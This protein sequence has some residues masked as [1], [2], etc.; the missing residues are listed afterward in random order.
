MDKNNNLMMAVGA[1]A[2]IFIVYV[3]CTK[4]KQTFRYTSAMPL[5]L[6]SKFDDPVVPNASTPNSPYSY[7]DMLN[8]APCSI[9]DVCSNGA[10]CVSGENHGPVCS[11]NPQKSCPSSLDWYATCVP[12]L[13]SFPMPALCS[14]CD[15][16]G[17][18]CRPAC[19]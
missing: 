18:N 10:I 12:N 9:R 19:C 8:G 11:N 5:P 17:E 1:L 6:C 14:N 4:S 16:N 15:K 13:Q 2:I 7:V 3:L